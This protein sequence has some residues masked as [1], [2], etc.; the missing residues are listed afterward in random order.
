MSNSAGGTTLKFQPSHGALVT[1]LYVART[2]TF[3][4]VQENEMKA[5]TFTNTLATIAFSVASGLFML[6]LGIR[7]DA[8]FQKELSPTG[9]ILNDI[10]APGLWVGSVVVF[11]VGVVALCYRRSMMNNIK[12]ESNTTQGQ[13]K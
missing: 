7:I 9:L 3:Y 6:G 13:R 4:A 12:K 8:Q 2:M 1:P 11:F 5:A 10:A